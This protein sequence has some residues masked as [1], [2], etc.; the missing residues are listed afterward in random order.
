MAVSPRPPIEAGLCACSRSPPYPGEQLAAQILLIMRLG[1]CR[2]CKTWHKV[3]RFRRR[4][5]ELKPQQLVRA[6]SSFYWD[7]SGEPG[8]ATRN[9]NPWHEF[10]L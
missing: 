8:S 6:G 4:R 7:S 1:I 2:T 9:D 10:S 3:R 5:Q